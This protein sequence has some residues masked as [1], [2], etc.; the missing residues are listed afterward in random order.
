MKKEQIAWLKTRDTVPSVG[1]KC[2]L[3]EA[4][5]KALQDLLW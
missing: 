3:L 5:V 4:R 1:E 2:K